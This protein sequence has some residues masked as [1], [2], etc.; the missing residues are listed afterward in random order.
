MSIV[1][2]ASHI[3]SLMQSFSSQLTD[4]ERNTVIA[5]AIARA[6]AYNLPIP[7]SPVNLVHSHYQQSFDQQVCNVINE[8]NE[9]LVVDTRLARDLT[10]KFYKFRYEMVFSPELYLDTLPLLAAAV[11]DLFADSVR[12]VI[13]KELTREDTVTYFNEWG[14]IVSRVSEHI[15]DKSS[16]GVLDTSTAI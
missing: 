13:S 5:T 2:L 7:S 6:L 4:R 12:S 8:F 10:F 11:P 3:R 14:R 16:N 15:R 1:T 9:Q